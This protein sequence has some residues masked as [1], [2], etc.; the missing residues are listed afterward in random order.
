MNSGN[1][2]PGMI[3]PMGERR[4]MGGESGAPP[5]QPLLP[6]QQPM[7][8]AQAPVPPVQPAA[9]VMQAQAP[10]WLAA[11]PAA[12]LAPLPPHGC[13]QAQVAN[14]A[15]GLR[16][17][18]P[19]SEIL[20]FFGNF[21]VT[22]EHLRAW[23]AE[24]GLVL[25][26]DV[27]PAPPASALPAPPQPAPVQQQAAPPQAV[28]QPAAP[29]PT[30]APSTPAEPKRGRRTKDDLEKITQMAAQGQTAAQ[31]SDAIGLKE[32][33]VQKAMEG[34]GTP[35]A[36]PARLVAGA[37]LPGTPDVRDLDETLRAQMLEDG[38]DVKYNGLKGGWD[39]IQAS[40]PRPSVRAPA[41]TPTSA[42]LAPTSVEPPPPRLTTITASPDAPAPASVERV[43]YGAMQVVHL[44]QTTGLSFE[45]ISA[46]ALALSAAQ[47]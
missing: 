15:D 27:S 22:V 3:P 34:L 40:S 17:G 36:P 4:T 46:T 24:L 21:G 1:G 31:I 23:A 10:S 13:T 2:A 35:D 9:P 16:A 37:F 20:G 12:P 30:A 41:P 6:Q 38:L 44:A 33:S 43:V 8:F 47:V 29:T 45:E 18:A 7:A 5:G 26:G 11:T 14:I 39:V 42:A 19:V 32:S 28:S 25:N